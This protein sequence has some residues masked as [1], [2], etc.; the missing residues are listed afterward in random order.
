MLHFF[1]FYTPIFFQRDIQ[2]KITEVGD[3]TYEKGI[4]QNFLYMGG[5]RQKVWKGLLANVQVEMIVKIA[6]ILNGS[7]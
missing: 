1:C 6:K 2:K 7:V 3:R 5:G 4:C